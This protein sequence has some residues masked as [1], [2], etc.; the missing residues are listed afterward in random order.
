MVQRRV[1]AGK[2]HKQRAS[3][4][5]NV[6]YQYCY[7]CVLGNAKRTTKMKTQ[8]LTG[9]TCPFCYIPHTSFGALEVVSPIAHNED[10]SYVAKGDAHIGR[11]PSFT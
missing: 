11:A 1:K 10:L 3:D 6:T 5:G 9:W 7:T 8:A 2:M 4:V